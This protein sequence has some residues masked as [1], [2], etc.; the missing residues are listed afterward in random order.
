VSEITIDVKSELED[1][2]EG[3]ERF[4]AVMIHRPYMRAG[5]CA[6][7][8]THAGLSYD[9]RRTLL[10]SRARANIRSRGRSQLGSHARH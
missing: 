10:V 2:F 7:M 4:V 8:V 1:V 5:L 3:N 9:P 6:L